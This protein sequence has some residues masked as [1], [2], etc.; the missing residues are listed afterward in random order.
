MICTFLSFD[1]VQ[2]EMVLDYKTY[3][4]AVV[5]SDQYLLVMQA[6]NKETE[7]GNLEKN[8]NQKS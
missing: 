4:R 8:E 7:E 6:E 2:L 3:P 1:L 5:K